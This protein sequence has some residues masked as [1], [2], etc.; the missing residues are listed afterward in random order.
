V[1]RTAV[2]ASFVAWLA[3]QEPDDVVRR[4]YHRCVDAYLA[5]AADNGGPSPAVRTYFEATAPHTVAT[6]A[7]S[8]AALDRF[9]EHQRILALTEIAR[10]DRRPWPDVC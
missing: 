2:F 3:G 8:R 6:A 4:R 9:D 5:F 7:V 10:P 1:D